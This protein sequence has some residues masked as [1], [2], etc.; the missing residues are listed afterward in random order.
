MVCTREE[1]TAVYDE[2]FDGDDAKKKKRRTTDDNG[3]AEMHSRWVTEGLADN[4]DDEHWITMSAAHVARGLVM[5]FS[6][7]LQQQQI[8]K[9]KEKLVA[10][11]KGERS[12]I[13]Q[14]VYVKIGTF[15]HEFNVQI[16]DSERYWQ[17][18]KPFGWAQVWQHCGSDPSKLASARA[19]AVLFT[20][21]MFCDFSMRFVPGS[22]D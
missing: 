5:H 12:I 6:N 20:L 1:V 2:V 11:Q 16:F 7:W 9:I 10:C 13:Q 17:K 18:A 4:H 8:K 19:L 21:E 3:F 14:L 22:R 15:V